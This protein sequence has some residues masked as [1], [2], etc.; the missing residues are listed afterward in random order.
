MDKN[1]M[2][3]IVFLNHIYYVLGR[4][5]FGKNVIYNL[6]QMILLIQNVYF[7]PIPQVNIVRK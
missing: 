1:I 6:K 7:K 5:L 3:F 4:C 2:N